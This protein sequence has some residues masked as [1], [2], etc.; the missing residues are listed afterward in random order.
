MVSEGRFM[1]IEWT[2]K[3]RL[4]ICEGKDV[5]AVHKIFALG[6]EAFG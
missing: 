4:P 6:C 2:D 5:I 3:L 1:K